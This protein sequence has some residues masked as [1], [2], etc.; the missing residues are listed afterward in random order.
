MFLLNILEIL[1]A[2][3]KASITAVALFKACSDF[4]SPNT[5]IV[6]PKSAQG[7]DI[8]Y[9]FVF[10]VFCLSIGLREADL[11]LKVSYQIT[12]TNAMEQG[13]S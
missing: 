13:P 11:A 3:Y 6:P 7:I 1:G 5:S 9:P 2:R 4:Y 8:I 12:P 10:T